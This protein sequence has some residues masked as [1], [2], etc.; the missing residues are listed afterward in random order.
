MAVKHLFLAI[1]SNKPMHGYEI[2][3]SFE[4]LV[5]N[6]W[7]L[8]FGQVYTTLTRLERDELL[9]IKE[10]IS[11]ERGEKKIYEITE[12]GLKY[13]EDWIISQDDW[14]IYYDEMAFKFSLFKV[15]DKDSSRQVL[16]RY[17]LYLIRLIKELTSLK[18][19]NNISEIDE[20]M[21]QRN[22]LKAEADVKWLDMCNKKLEG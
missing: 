16:G 13:L 5:S 15:L 8:N 21:I 11:E 14:S 4:E 17:R 10:V 12:K 18:L 3:T 19:K 22:I 7:P 20:L 1:I 6:Q 9:R 2:K